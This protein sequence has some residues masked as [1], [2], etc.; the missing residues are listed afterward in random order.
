MVFIDGVFIY[1]KNDNLSK[2]IIFLFLKH[3]KKKIE[4]YFFRF[5]EFFFLYLN[6]KN[7]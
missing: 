4:K 7:L 6:L 5:S 3:I 2:I 1:N